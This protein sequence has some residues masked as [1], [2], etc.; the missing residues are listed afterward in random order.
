MDND[1]AKQRH[2]QDPITVQF[3]PAELMAL[4]SF[5]ALGAHFAATTSGEQSPFSPNDVRSHIAIIG[6]S[7]S[8]TLTG[9][10]ARAVAVAR[11]R[12]REQLPKTSP[13][14]GK[15]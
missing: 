12:H 11:E 14:V 4:Y 3:E 2:R 8:N 7:A 10:L 6:E 9:K 13:E 1:E 15:I 5:L